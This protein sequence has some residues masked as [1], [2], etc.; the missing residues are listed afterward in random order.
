MT[1]LL[2]PGPIPT[3]R[4]RPAAIRD[5]EGG[6]DD[7]GGCRPP[8]KRHAEVKVR[9][10]VY[11]DD[12]WSVVVEPEG[13]SF[14]LMLRGTLTSPIAATLQERFGFVFGREA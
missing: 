9:L 13:Q 6:D 11:D 8:F 12:S 14:D 7:R 4:Y 1:V 5:D 2:R 10:I 3:G